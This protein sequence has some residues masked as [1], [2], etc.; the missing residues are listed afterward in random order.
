[1]LTSHKRFSDQ[2]RESF[3]KCTVYNTN[4]SGGIKK[5]RRNSLSKLD[6]SK[7]CYVKA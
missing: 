5:D 2:I 6:Q 1:M 4:G 3:N 7:G